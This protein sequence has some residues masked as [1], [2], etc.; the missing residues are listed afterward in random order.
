MAYVPYLT[1]KVRPDKQRQNYSINC[2]FPEPKYSNIYY[3]FR[4]DRLYLSLHGQITVYTIISI[5]GVH[6]IYVPYLTQKVIPDERRQNYMINCQ[7]VEPKYSNIY[8]GF[9]LDRTYLSQHW[10]KNLY[11]IFP[12]GGVHMIYVPYLT[13]KVRTDEQRQ[14]Y[15]TNGKFPEPKY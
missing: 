7:F 6:M 4:L 1:Q 10:Q 9:R 14:N 11:T 12:I 15:L 8:H 3:A 13:Q 5:E 2:K